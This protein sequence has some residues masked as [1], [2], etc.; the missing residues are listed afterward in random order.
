MKA[1]MQK[2][3]ATA[4]FGLTK[5]TPEMHQRLMGWVP[6]A[7]S[8]KMYGGVDILAK[9]D[10]NAKCLAIWDWQKFNC[11]ASYV[12]DTFE[13]VMKI[14]SKMGSNKL[15]LWFWAWQNLLTFDKLNIKPNKWI[16]LNTTHLSTCHLL[17]TKKKKY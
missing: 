8:P 9:D 11:E 10:D 16:R 3:R 12:V 5:W 1:I 15:R 6:S 14:E 7:E 17:E 13:M 4:I 2:D